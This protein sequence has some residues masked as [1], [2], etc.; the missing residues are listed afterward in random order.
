MAVAYIFRHKNGGSSS[1]TY[2]P[3][4][5]GEQPISVTNGQIFLFP[6]ESV[7]AAGQW[8]TFF[9]IYRNTGSFVMTSMFTDNYGFP[10][11]GEVVN[12]YG[13][14][15]YSL[16]NFN[17]AVYGS[18][19]AYAGGSHYGL[20]KETYLEKLVNGNWQTQKTLPQNHRVIIGGG[21]GYTYSNNANFNNFNR[22]RCW[23]YKNASGIV[24][25]TTGLYVRV[26]DITMDS[27]SYAINTR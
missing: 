14:K 3:M 27:G 16:P 8:R 12:G 11:E 17:K 20:R 10:K 18:S 6:D 23:G 9:Y 5:I 1:R 4:G 24:I 25:E 15:L 13:D 21:Q 7:D 26:R 2:E 22:L 19:Y